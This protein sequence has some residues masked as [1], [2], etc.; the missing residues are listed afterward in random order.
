MDCNLARSNS[1]GEEH[2]Y[3]LPEKP[4]LASGSIYSAVFLWHKP[5]EYQCPSSTT[6]YAQNNCTAS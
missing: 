5:M 6:P 4:G 1:A 3:E 2:G